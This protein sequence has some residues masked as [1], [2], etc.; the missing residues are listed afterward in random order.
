MDK[1]RNKKHNNWK[2]QQNSRNN[3]FIEQNQKPKFYPSSYENR[4][5]NQERLKAIEEI[6]TRKNI[7]P[8]CNLPITDIASSLTDKKTNQPVH[9]DCVLEEVRKNEKINENEKIAYIGQGRFGILYYENIRDQKHFTIKKIIEWEDK[10][11]KS[12]WRGE[13]SD[14]YSKIN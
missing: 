12:Q 13:I 4:E 3:N 6:K 8:M 9:F 1:H 7:C 2:N 5:S 10:E 11:T 14:L